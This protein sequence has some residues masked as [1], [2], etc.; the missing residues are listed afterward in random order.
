MFFC[1]LLLLSVATGESLDCGFQPN[2]FYPYSQAISCAKS[3]PFNATIAAHTVTNLKKA[4]QLYAFR[5]IAKNPPAPFSPPV[6][7]DQLDTL[8]S[9]TWEN[10]FDFQNAIRSKFLQLHDA[11]TNYYAPEPERFTFT[12][13][14]NFFSY[15]NDQGMLTIE[16][17]N[18]TNHNGQDGSNDYS[19][20]VG[21]TVSQVDGQD[22]I[23]WAKAQSLLHVGSS[24]DPQVRFNLL[25]L[26]KTPFGLPTSWLGL[27]S[28]RTHHF[29]PAPISPS[30]NVT[31]VPANGG[32]PVALSLPWSADCGSCDYAST[33]EY[34]AAY[35][36]PQNAA[37]PKKAVLK[38]Q[39]QLSPI[40]NATMDGLAFYRLDNDTLVW[41]QDTF[42]PMDYFAY[43]EAVFEGLFG[44]EN[45]ANPAKN[46]ILD[47]TWNGGGDICL[48]RSMLKLLFPKSRNFNP[49]DLPA[50]PL[51]LNLTRTA[52]SHNITNTEWSGSFYQSSVSGTQYSN[53]D[54]S[55]MIPG[56]D[57]SSRGT[58]S[59][60]V[61]ISE[62]SQQ[63]GDPPFSFPNSPLFQPDRV[64]FVSRGFCGSTCA[65]FAD[66]LH[67]HLDIQTV[68]FGGYDSSSGM[69]YRSFPGLEVLEA[70]GFFPVLDALLQ[71]T[72]DQTQT[73]SLA[74]RQLLTSATFRVCIRE[75]YRDVNHTDV[76]L[77]YVQQNSNFHF[78][79]TRDQAL[80]PENIWSFTRSKVLAND[81]LWKK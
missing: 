22:P 46:L 7:L 36:H 76:P 59:E 29:S 63:C 35:Y 71:D 60:L 66:S 27:M 34:K 68:T 55:W 62:I 9:D 52:V 31:L 4:M 39:R 57:R 78:P 47:F 77:E 51:A 15:T 26:Q 38:K 54:S 73:D 37:V 50:T 72:A 58:F 53:N 67:D 64:A 23:V 6:D 20:Y 17:A 8:L 10:D 56:I 48:G 80:E 61:E 13:P 25:F 28:W 14:L 79:L 2:T 11:H 45:G 5:T 70:G 41:Y 33:A 19:K 16:V 40:S 12:L 42:A 3:F 74:P 81:D 18:I 65:L 75:A 24:K 44:S 21:A 30:L 32:A 1:I 69:A 49:T 43:Y